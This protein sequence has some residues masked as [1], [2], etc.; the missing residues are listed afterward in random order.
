MT[1]TNHLISGDPLS[2][3]STDLI[4]QTANLPVDDPVPEGWR[5]LTGNERTS[6]IGRLA[7]RYEIETTVMHESPPCQPLAT[8]ITWREPTHADVGKI[9]VIRDKGKP[10]GLWYEATVKFINGEFVAKTLNPTDMVKR[11]FEVKNPIA[12]PDTA[13]AIAFAWSKPDGWRD[14]D[15]TDVGVERVIRLNGKTFSGTVFNTTAPF[16]GIYVARIKD[17]PTV[18][19]V[20]GF[21][22][23]K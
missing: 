22:V 10:A 15:D 1:T 4:A 16:P 11:N 18:R 20:T 12:S 6:L 7:C 5:V 14:P 8:S 3:V 13:D 9:F 2:P 21:D 17:G 19:V 23:S